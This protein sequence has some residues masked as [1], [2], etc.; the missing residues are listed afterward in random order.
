V[1]AN[2]AFQSKS[3]ASFAADSRLCLLY[4]LTGSRFS[5]GVHWSVAS[6]VSSSRIFAARAAASVSP[7]SVS[8]F[9]R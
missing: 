7:A 9:A 2:Q 5:T 6:F 3:G 1:A 4:V 8:S